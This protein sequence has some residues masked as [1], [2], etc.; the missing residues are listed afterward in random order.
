[1]TDAAS[2]IHL[3][4]V[5]ANRRNEIST[6]EPH[7][8]YQRAWSRLDHHMF[9][10]LREFINEKGDFK[11]SLDWPQLTKLFHERFAPTTLCYLYSLDLC[12]EIHAP[13]S[14]RAPDGSKAPDF[15]INQKKRGPALI[16]ITETFK[17]VWPSTSGEPVPVTDPKQMYIE[18]DGSRVTKNNPLKAITQAK[19]K[20]REENAQEGVASE[21]ASTS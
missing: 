9:S 8:F 18:A 1:M 6:S 10:I 16:P 2:L 14:T 5:L 19:E 7:V 3:S 13:L 21:A 11:R 12:L 15:D 20:V 17:S 4:S